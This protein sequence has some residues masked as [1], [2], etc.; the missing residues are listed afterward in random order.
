MR[1]ELKH[2]KDY[3]NTEVGVIYATYMFRREDEELEKGKLSGISEISEGGIFDITMRRERDNARI[4]DGRGHFK[5]LL[6]PLSTLLN[7][8][9]DYLLD[10]HSTDFFADTNHKETVLE[11]LSRGILHYYIEFLPNGLVEWLT[12]NHYDIHN[13]IEKDLA[14]DINTL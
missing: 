14:Y 1:L 5:L 4:Q 3:L 12:K 2:V 11:G 10:V 9:L 6:K 8:D 7:G 13:L